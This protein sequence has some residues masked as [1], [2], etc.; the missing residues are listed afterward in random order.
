MYNYPTEKTPVAVQV[1]PASYAQQQ[2]QQQP[3]PRPYYS[4]QH[5]R[6]DG[7]PSTCTITHHHAP[8][9]N[10]FW[11][12]LTSPL[13][14]LTYQLI[15][16]HLVNFVFAEIAFVV[17]VVVGSI[18]IATIP[19]FCLGLVVLQVLLYAVHFFANVDAHL[20]N[21]IAPIHE[22]LVV[23]FQVPRRG[24]YQVSGYRISPDL[25]RFSKEAFAAI[26][27]FVFVKFPL[28]VVFS[29]SVLALLACSVAL[30][31]YPSVLEPIIRRHN[32][33]DQNRSIR[34]FRLHVNME[35]FEPT[36]IVL[37]GVALLYVT[38]GLLHL[39]GRVHRAT[40][41]FFTCE[42][43]ATSGFVIQGS[44]TQQPQF[45]ASAPQY[46]AVPLGPQP[47][48][49]YAPQVYGDYYAPQAPP[50]YDQRRRNA[51][52]RFASKFG[53]AFVLVLLSVL[54]LVFSVG[55]FV[56]VVVGL[57]LTVGLLPAACI[58]LFVLQ[59]LIWVVK[60]LA[61]ADKWLHDQRQ[62]VYI[63]LLRDD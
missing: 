38:I 56:V 17:V 10:G 15:L 32:N 23:Q 12:A 8:K 5:P 29:S 57:A 58:G 7:A 37:M 30:T 26:F 25:S 63:D 61:N 33:H 59:V 42:F 40:T 49:M 2:Q 52:E 55:M 3:Q 48:T 44:H 36:Q 41:K 28:A 27:Y 1:V 31:L 14:P 46:S 4:Y 22:Q 11:Y 35:D 39:F 21:C 45:P 18:G 47:T 24:L 60:P 50:L 19:L 51:F 16:F 43:F 62:R 53:S 9:T 34:I 6:S 54:S 13:R 20:Y